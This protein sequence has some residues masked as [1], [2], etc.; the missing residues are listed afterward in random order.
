[1]IVDIFDTFFIPY[2]NEHVV[3]EFLKYT[4]SIQSLASK[5]IPVYDNVES[6][7]DARIKNSTRISFNSA[8][9][10]VERNLTSNGGSQLT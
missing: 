9:L 1:M 3:Y 6:A 5:T 2:T 10:I 8:K 7:V 4:K